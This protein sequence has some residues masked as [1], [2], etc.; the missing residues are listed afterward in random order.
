MGVF[1]SHMRGSHTVEVGVVH[2][3]W[4][5]S[6][7]TC[8][9]RIPLKSAITITRHARAPF[10]SALLT[11]PFLTRGRVLSEL[12]LPYELYPNYDI[13]DFGSGKPRL[14]PVLARVCWLLT[15]S[16]LTCDRYHDP[17]SVNQPCW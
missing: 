2:R 6:P 12:Y 7:V 13:G 8:E 5:S 3:L 1:T 15:T 11:T 4:A 17:E 9:D 16:H 10:Q 14:P